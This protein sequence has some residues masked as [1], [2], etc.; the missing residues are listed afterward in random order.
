MQDPR[1]RTS[2][3]NGLKATIIMRGGRPVY[4]TAVILW[5]YL[6]FG[7]MP[8]GVLGAFLCFS[9]RVVYPAYPAA[10]NIF[11]LTPLDHQVFAGALMWVFGTFVYL[12]PTIIVTV[13]LLSPDSWGTDE[14]RLSRREAARDPVRRTWEE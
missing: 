1:P 8:C 13:R 14:A 11:G 6:F 2:S 3:T 10:P 7:M 9:D 5:G 4:N 12:V